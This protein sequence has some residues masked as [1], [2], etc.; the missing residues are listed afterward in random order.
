MPFPMP[1]LEPVTTTTRLSD[2]LERCLE[3][4][5]LTSGFDVE[6][7]G[8]ESFLS[9]EECSYSDTPERTAVWLFP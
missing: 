8:M 4:D 5:V 7:A 3:D 2:M 1:R 9:L 6:T